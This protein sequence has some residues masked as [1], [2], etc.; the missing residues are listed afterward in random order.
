[1]TESQDEKYQCSRCKKFKDASKYGARG[2][3]QRGSR[4]VPYWCTECFRGWSRDRYKQ[5][6]EAQKAESKKYNQRLRDRLAGLK[7]KPC[8][9]CGVSYPPYVMDWDHLDGFE[10]THNISE[11]MRRRFA[12]AK[13]EAEIAK[14]EL[15]CANC[16]RIR[17]HERAI[18]AGELDENEID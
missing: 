11:M 17:T 6:P 4:P 1:V 2:K 16:H 18:R 8:A 3:N 10:K 14:C 9:D 12:W 7:G 5:D 13:I 15:V